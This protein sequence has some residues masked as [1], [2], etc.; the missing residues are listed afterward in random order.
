MGFCESQGPNLKKGTMVCYY[1]NFINYKVNI[2]IINNFIK[3]KPFN[4]I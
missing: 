2:L 3:I 1:I 4:N